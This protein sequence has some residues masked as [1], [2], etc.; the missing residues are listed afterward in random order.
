M[1]ERIAERIM[2]WVVGAMVESLEIKL[3]EIVCDVP[4]V[5][6]WIACTWTLCGAVIAACFVK[7]VFWSRH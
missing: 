4:T 5:W 6:L 7:R 1:T 3:A 2:E